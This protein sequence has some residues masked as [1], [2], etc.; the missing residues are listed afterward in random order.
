MDERDLPEAVEWVLKVYDFCVPEQNKTVC[1]K[2]RVSVFLTYQMK[3]I[4][5]FPRELGALGLPLVGL[6]FQYTGEV[7]RREKANPKEVSLESKVVR[8]PQER[9]NQPHMQYQMLKCKQN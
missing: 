6:L 8:V 3:G 7:L 2:S 4:A 9:L 1:I 5:N